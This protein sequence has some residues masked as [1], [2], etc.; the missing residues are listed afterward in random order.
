VVLHPR[1]QSADSSAERKSVPPGIVD[2]DSAT[3]QLGRTSASDY[4]QEVTF[5]NAQATW[6]V[7]ARHLE[8]FI[9]AWEQSPLPPIADHLP[10]GPSVLRKLAL[11]EL[12]KVDIEQRFATGQGRVLE[13]YVRE[14]P[15]I[16]DEAGPP[17]ELIYEEFHIRNRHGFGLTPSDCFSRFPGRKVELAKLLGVER[18]VASAASYDARRPRD[19]QVGDQIDDFDLLLKLGS[20]AFATVYLARQRS[21]NRLVA[22][23]I[24]ADRGAEARTLAFLDHPNIVRVFDERRL[25]EQKLRLVYMQYASGGTLADLIERVRQIPLRER[26]GKYLVE[27]VNEAAERAGLGLLGDPNLLAATAQLSWPEV[28]CRIGGSLARALDHAHRNGVLHRDVKPAN[29]LLAGDGSPK[30]ADFNISANATHPSI[31]AAAYFGGSLAYMSPEHLEAFNP[32]HERT[33]EELDHRAD[34]YSLAVVLWELLTGEKP[35]R[36]LKIDGDWGQTLAAMTERRK[37]CEFASAPDR[38]DESVCNLYEVLERA[39]SP[40]PADRP[41]SGAEFAHELAI[42]AQ[43]KTRRLVRLSNRGWREWVR[44]FPVVAVLTVVTVPNIIASLFNIAYNY[45]AIV[46]NIAL[47]DPEAIRAFNQL[48]LIINGIA[49]TVGALLVVRFVWPVAQLVKRTTDLR[50]LDPQIL[51]QRRRQALQLG[52]W[53]ALLGIVEWTIAGVLWPL[54]LELKTNNSAMQP[55]DYPHFLISLILCGL[56]A[57]AY[58]FLGVTFIAVRVLLPALL[59][60]G[61]VDPALEEDLRRAGRH[62]GIYFLIACGVP[63]LGLSILIMTGAHN[64]LKYAEVILGTLALTSLA[65]LAFAFKTYSVI[66]HDIDTMVQALRPSDAF[67]IESTTVRK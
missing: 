34:L 41:Q 2:P 51:H 13:D 44:R 58:P 10:A 5:D 46:E 65:G 62:A 6:D 35:F 31:G 50:Q 49:Y 40:D 53:A 27:V 26:S 4:P 15:E 48:M 37:R 12:I 24:S 29:I 39:L 33:P 32:R 30:L 8:S 59:T 20:G 17:C 55:A 7:L 47:R 61:A 45:L 18:T 64:T 63:L 60:R 21:I 19:Y 38:E 16:A 23:K 52:S 43:A 3:L 25:P 11:V 56:A 67:G 9:T 14:F 22:L 28:V 54:A 57:A 66:L 1:N 36:D 42:C